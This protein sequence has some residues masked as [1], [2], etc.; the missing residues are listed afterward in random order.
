MQH[1][2]DALADAD[3]LPTSAA[4]YA[5]HEGRHHGSSS[6]AKR[7]LNKRLADCIATKLGLGRGAGG[8]AAGSGDAGGDEA[9]GDEAG[10][11]EAVVCRLRAQYRRLRSALN[12]KL[13]ERGYLLEPLIAA[14]R[15][16]AIQFT[17]APKGALAKVRKAIMKDAAA[18][19]RSWKRAMSKSLKHHRPAPG[20]GRGDRIG[21]G[22]R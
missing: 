10:G 6:A 7:R 20:G 15:L 8:D 1:D 16:D 2:H 17:R 13:A 3:S 4:K 14:K 22:A 12:K 11:D 21:I 19:A 18:A 9:G 5:P